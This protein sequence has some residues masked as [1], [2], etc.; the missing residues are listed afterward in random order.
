MKALVGYA[1]ALSTEAGH[2]AARIRAKHR[3]ERRDV[4]AVRERERAEKEL[5]RFLARWS[6][7]RGD[8]PG[9]A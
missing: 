3:A 5:G 6:N 9:A 1:G 4:K 8:Q 7:G 2:K